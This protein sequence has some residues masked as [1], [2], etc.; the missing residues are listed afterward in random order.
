VLDAGCGTG[1]ITSRLAA[2]YPRAS[3]LGVDVLDA[4]LELARM[5]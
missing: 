1:E 2:H 4:H 5:R 3:V